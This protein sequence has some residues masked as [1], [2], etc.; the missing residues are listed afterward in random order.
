MC[1]LCVSE[2]NEHLASASLLSHST[3]FPEHAELFRRY[4]RA[5]IGEYR[6]SGYKKQPNLIVRGKNPDFR[7]ASSNFSRD[8]SP[9]VSC[10]PCSQ[11]ILLLPL[12]H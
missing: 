9:N 12:V 10:F 3:M 2:P 11:R 4:Y 6:K 1:S 7:R 8:V 5:R